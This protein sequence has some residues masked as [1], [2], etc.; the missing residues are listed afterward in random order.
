NATAELVEL[1]SGDDQ[2]KPLDSATDL[3]ENTSESLALPQQESS[4]NPEKEVAEKE[5][6]IAA[7][8]ATDLDD[9]RPTE[10]A[11]NSVEEKGSIEN[12]SF[13]AEENVTATEEAPSQE[14]QKEEP[15]MPVVAARSMDQA[16][17]EV[18]TYKETPDYDTA[19]TEIDHSEPVTEKPAE[20]EAQKPMMMTEDSR[21]SSRR[22]SKA[23][24]NMPEARKQSIGSRVSSRK[25][26]GVR[27]KAIIDLA[28]TFD[29]RDLIEQKLASQKS[30]KR[31]SWASSKSG[32][33]RESG[34]A[35]PQI[36]EDE[37]PVLGSRRDSKTGEVIR[38]D[39]APKQERESAPVWVKKS[40]VPEQPAVEEKVDEA[41]V[42]LEN[43][44]VAVQDKDVVEF[45]E[46][47]NDVA[48][49]TEESFSEEAAPSDESEIQA[50][51]KEASKKSLSPELSLASVDVEAVEEKKSVSKA[52]LS[53]ELSLASVDVANIAIDEQEPAAP[54][55]EEP[56]LKGIAEEKD[57]ESTEKPSNN[58]ISSWFKPIT[59]IFSK[60]DKDPEIVP[61]AEQDR[62][63]APAEEEQQ[64]P[65]DVDEVIEEVAEPK[66]RVIFESK[67]VENT[68]VELSPEE[69]QEWIEKEKQ[70]D[71]ENI[72]QSNQDG[73]EAA[74]PSKSQES[75]DFFAAETEGQQEEAFNDSEAVATRG[76][77]S[78]SLA[79]NSY[80]EQEVLG[81]DERDSNLVEQ[82]SEVLG[83][84]VAQESAEEKQSLSEAQKDLEEMASIPADST[85]APEQQTTPSYEHEPAAVEVAE[86]YEVD[87]E[88]EQSESDLV[89]EIDNDA[90][91]E[92]SPVTESQSIESPVEEIQEAVKQEDSV[93]AEINP[94][95]A[96]EDLAANEQPENAT[97]ELV[98]L[99]SGDDQEKPLDSATD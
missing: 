51:A 89:D 46:S 56:Q 82:S 44:D 20:L 84:A 95:D 94:E 67:P 59:S 24:I 26:S 34:N 70:A 18:M 43:N 64:H 65:R 99:K 21:N 86:T 49:A 85:P 38:K 11:L 60:K 4:E 7:D 57:E 25:S 92:G 72:Q 96:S 75:T 3:T 9:S 58:R 33:R 14:A 30:S 69:I 22:Q 5:A 87:S 37:F 27:N 16:L 19:T 66:E 62:E 81:E 93:N 73:H 47:N 52:S 8:S 71:V 23:S 90:R 88:L 77:P 54:V 31:N 29:N 53:P 91:P 63:L 6:D 78:E 40:S 36:T 17:E 76:I 12:R 41:P 50:L 83:E 68:D 74:S 39:V 98:E 28:D 1:K 61:D 13:D 42:V 48:P 15:E 35:V 45:S 80:D 2:E 55:S 79:E 10:E 97:A 32:S